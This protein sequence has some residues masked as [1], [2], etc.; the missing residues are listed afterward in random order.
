[1]LSILLQDATSYLERKGISVPENFISYLTQSFL[2]TTILHEEK[3]WIIASDLE[4]LLSVLNFLVDAK[5]IPLIGSSLLEEGI[6]AYI[7]IN[8]HTKIELVSKR[9]KCTS[10]Y[11]SF[12]K[13]LITF[14]S[15]IEKSISLE[16]KE[17]VSH[18][19]FAKVQ[20]SSRAVSMYAYNQIELHKKLGFIDPSQFANSASYLGSKRTLSGFIIEAITP[21]TNKDTIIFDLM[22]GSGSFATSANKAWET[23][24]SDALAFSRTLATV[25]GGGYNKQRADIALTKI[26]N[27]AKPHS[28]I[29]ST[30]F[31]DFLEEEDK[32]FHGDSSDKLV[33][34]YQRFIDQFPTY[35]S[36]DTADYLIPALNISIRKTDH[37]T[38]P[39]CLFSSYFANTYF[40]LR[41]C[42]EIDSLRFAIGQLLDKD[43]Q[44]W[45]LGALVASISA[46]GTTYGG[47][48]AQPKI[49]SSESINSR[50][51]STIIERRAASITHEFSIR[52]SSLAKLSESAPRV[53]KTIDGPWPNA[54]ST[55]TR[56]VNSKNVLVYLD[57]PYTREEYSRYY[58]VLETLVNYDY[59]S[60]IGRGKTPDKKKMERF[61]SEFSTRSKTKLAAMIAQVIQ[62]ILDQG[63]VCAWSY[64]S[65]GLA[66]I[67]EVFEFVAETHKFHVKSF[68]APYGYKQQGA[69]HFRKAS[70]S[71]VLEYLFLI[72][73]QH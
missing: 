50:N 53:I 56:T 8:G 5:E 45:A 55:L 16:Q 63:W 22:C 49:K 23:Y 2:L 24:A 4:E 62:S 17:E 1:M 69:K 12:I 32:L 52:F 3:N 19:S 30:H 33:S 60:T 51:I 59:P 47:H 20:T 70:Q 11:Y 46:L 73:L 26:L 36:D 48:F 43:D 28:E 58:H 40:G 67:I 41:Q 68:S 31:S 35:S 10:T 29:L 6:P 37:S 18:L 65:I 27:S 9:S 34:E 54:L 42:V 61:N 72:S 15:N 13:N 57:A 38:Y 66:D 44:Q 39:Y 64:S 7:E 21:Y 71:E 25:Q 14:A